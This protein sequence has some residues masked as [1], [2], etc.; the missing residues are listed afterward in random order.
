MDKAWRLQRLPIF[1]LVYRK[2]GEGVEWGTDGRCL[3]EVL[4]R[5]GK[6]MDA[7]TCARSAVSQ[8]AREERAASPPPLPITSKLP[9]VPLRPGPGF[10]GCTLQLI[11]S[12]GWSSG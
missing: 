6:E 1:A 8:F 11:G 7:E 9:W 5:G 3:G 4:E 10:C 12:T 2:E